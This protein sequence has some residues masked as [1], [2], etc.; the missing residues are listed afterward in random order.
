MIFLRAHV[1]VL[2][3]EQVVLLGAALGGSF[4]FGFYGRNV[5]ESSITSQKERAPAHEAVNSKKEESD[6]AL[7]FYTLG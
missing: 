5:T 7:A 2:A 4:F 1:A 3:R 6:E